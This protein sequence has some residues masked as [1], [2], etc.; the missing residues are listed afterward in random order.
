MTDYPGWLR[1]AETFV[2]CLDYLP[3]QWS[4]TIAVEPP[5]AKTKA[6]ELR[7]NLPLGLPACLYDLY[8]IGSA[9]FSCTYSWKPDESHLRLVEPILPHQY[10]LYGGAHIVPAAE[11]EDVQYAVRSWMRG[12]GTS[13]SSPPK[14]G[15]EIWDQ[16]VPFVDF[17]NGDYLAIRVV[18]G[19]PRQPVLYLDHEDASEGQ[20]AIEISPGFDQFLAD[21]ETL[22]YLWPICWSQEFNED[23]RNGTLRAD[24]P[25]VAEWRR[26]IGGQFAAKGA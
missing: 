17:N 4:I 23:A 18:G 15:W 1:R 20:N 14:P 11:L 2:R 24:Q 12:W 26:I 8:T 9:S 25:E 3:G 16:C 7:E 13:N 22:C 6:N 19:D 10:S 5:L 21:M